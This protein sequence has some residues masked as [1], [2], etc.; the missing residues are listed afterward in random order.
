MRKGISNDV[1]AFVICLCLHIIAVDVLHG[2]ALGT[3]LDFEDGSTGWTLWTASSVEMGFPNTEG[4]PGTDGIVCSVKP[5]FMGVRAYSGSCFFGA[6]CNYQTKNGGAYQQ[7]PATPGETYTVSVWIYTYVLPYPPEDAWSLLSYV[8]IDPTGGTDPLSS[9]IVWSNGETSQEAWKR[10][11]VSAV[12]RSSTITIF[13][14]HVQKWKLEWNISCFD[15]VE[16][17]VGGVEQ[18]TTPPAAVNN[19]QATPGPNVGEVTLTWTS[20]GDDGMEGNLTGSYRI[21]YNTE[22]TGWN[23]NSAQVTIPASN[24]SPGTVQSRTVGNLVGGVTYY[25]ALWTCDEGNRCSGMSNIVSTYAKP[26]PTGDGGVTPLPVP[27]LS[28]PADGASVVTTKPTFSWQAVQSP[29]PGA[30]VTYILQVDD[31]IDFNSLVINITT[32]DTSFTPTTDLARGTT[33]YWRVK[34]VDTTGRQ[35]DWS[36][37]WRFYVKSDAVQPSL[38]AP[39]LISPINGYLTTTTKPTFSWQAVQSPTPGASV[40]YILQ[41][42]DNI[43]FNSPV[44]NITTSD[45]SFTPTTD[46]ARGT[47]YYWRVKAADTTGR[48]SDW[49]QV[50]RFY[51]YKIDEMPPLFTELQSPMPNVV[52]LKEAKQEKKEVRIRY[53]LSEPRKIELKIYTVNGEL[54]KTLVD[55]EL[56]DEGEHEMRWDVKDKNGNYVNSGVYMVYFKAGKMTKVAKI[57]VV[58]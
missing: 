5:W 46:L 30:S 40:T 36:Q 38:S 22:N 49:S 52:K 48:Q 34:A 15:K 41:V 20:P 1:I 4:Q 32:S 58:K 18:D 31:N 13:L 19:L 12:A 35:S 53:T 42:D 24:V 54:V 29:T 50:W 44:I 8:G 51:I 37:V 9:E 2:Q 27:N 39:T 56:Q 47:T 25:F 57:I 3:N 45:T 26:S 21:Q 55:K 23:M 16:I 10:I 33:Y 7:I 11:E 17:T 28:S 43:N 6:A 14:R